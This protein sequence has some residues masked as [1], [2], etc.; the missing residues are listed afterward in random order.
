MPAPTSNDRL[1]LQAR[2]GFCRAWLA[3]GL[4]LNL[5]ISAAYQ[6]LGNRDYPYSTF[7]YRPI[8]R[9]QDFYSV[10]RNT[11]RLDP[12]TARAAI[13]TQGEALLDVSNYFP[14][15]HAVFY[16]FTWI[17][18]GW[19][20]A[21]YGTIVAAGAAW[22]TMRIAPGR[23]R[24]ESAIN[25]AVFGWLSYPVLFILDRGN[26][27]A[28]PFAL[29][30]GAATLAHRDRWRRAS[31]LLGLAGAIKG[32]PLVFLALGLRR[33]WRW[34]ALGALVAAGATAGALLLLDG[35]IGHNL[36]LLREALARFNGFGFYGVNG[37]SASVSAFGG[38]YGAYAWFTGGLLDPSALARYF[39]GYL[40]FAAAVGGAVVAFAVWGARLR[41]W[42]RWFLIVACLQTLPYPSYEYKLVYTLIPLALL[43]WD[44]GQTRWTL[45]YLTLLCLIVMPKGFPVLFSDVRIGTVL[46]PLLILGTGALIVSE[47]AGRSSPKHA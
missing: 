34:P 46:S 43:L 18:E 16:P 1:K 17:P 32:L 39:A 33:S 20:M 2:I 13:G 24:L 40:P 10:L 42:Q 30:A 15:T 3:T 38:I 23:T 14:L 12:Y 19:A 27:E 44:A 41:E 26:I 45:T 31:V 37:V 36:A 9:F 21:L 5:A 7:L 29:A 35:G 6:L 25:V 28:L 47:A 11:A 22:A 8:D 4:G